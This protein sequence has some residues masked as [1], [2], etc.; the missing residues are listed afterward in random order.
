MYRRK[1]IENL[2][3]APSNFI[4]ALILGV[5][6]YIAYPLTQSL[7]LQRVYRNE[8]EVAVIESVNFDDA[9]Y[10]STTS[11]FAVGN[12]NDRFSSL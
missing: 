6:T 2:S 4:K 7:Q 1:L 8:Y 3:D 5:C 11:D 12:S 10:S 9:Q